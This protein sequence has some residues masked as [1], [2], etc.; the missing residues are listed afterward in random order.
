MD[1]VPPFP[2]D[3]QPSEAVQPGDRAL[4]VPPVDSE[5]GTVGHTAGGDHRFDALGPDEAAVLV[6]VAT[7]V[8]EQ[9]RGAIA[10]CLLP[11]PGNADRPISRS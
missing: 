8:P 10:V 4:D 3:A 7:P 5:S 11:G 1:V 9:V 6:V 2:A